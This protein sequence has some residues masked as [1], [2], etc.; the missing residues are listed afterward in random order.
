MRIFLLVQVNNNGPISF[1]QGMPGSTPRPFPVPESPPFFSAYW[2][3]V[4]TRPDN[5]GHVYYRISTE[6]ALLNRA[7][8]EISSLFAQ[9]RRRFTARWLF[10]VTWEMVGYYNQ[11]TDRVCPYNQVF[12]CMYSTSSKKQQCV[13]ITILFLL[14]P[15]RFRV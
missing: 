9:R 10:I 8:N 14:R 11:N 1:D 6:Q 12:R 3:D 15:T 2:A 4:D 7:S 13:H 5:G